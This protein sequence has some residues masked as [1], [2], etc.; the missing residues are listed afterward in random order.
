MPVTNWL[1]MATC[2]RAVH[3]GLCSACQF[4]LAGTFHRSFNT[5]RAFVAFVVSDENDCAGAVLAADMLR[6]PSVRDLVSIGAVIT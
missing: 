6:W 2:R 3:T 1:W 5:E 4:G